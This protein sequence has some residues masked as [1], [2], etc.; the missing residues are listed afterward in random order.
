[1]SFLKNT[2]ATLVGLF[3]FFGLILLI[4]IGII[5]A[6]L[7][8]DE[9]TVKERSILHLKLDKPISEWEHDDPLGEFSFLTNQPNTIGVNKLV[10]TIKAAKE[11]DKIKGIYLEASMLMAG[12]AHIEEIRNALDDFS[13][14][15]KF[16]ITYSELYSEGA[17]Y[18]A[19]VADS[20]F[21][22][23]EGTIDFNG[24]DAE[25]TFYKG[26]LDKLE[27][28]PQ[29]FRV[30]DFKSAV[31]PI[32]R[33]DMSEANRLQL[34]SIL[35]SMYNHVLRNM[36]ESRGMAVERLQEI[37]AQMEVRNPQDA[38]RLKM[39]DRLY[40]LDQVYNSMRSA[41]GL[42]K[43]EKVAL[44]TYDKYKKTVKAYQKADDEIA[45]IVAEGEIVPGEGDNG[46][47]GSEKYAKLIRKARLDDDIKAI[48]LRINSPGGSFIASD[49]MWREVV[50]ARKEKPVIASM[51]NVAASGGYYMAM[52]CDT[53][54]A[55]PNTIT[56][57]IGIF[58]VIF[59]ASEFLENK[60]G[61]TT[62]RVK[63]GE[64]SNLLTMTRSLNDAEKEII[65]KDINEGYETFTSK[66]AQGRN[67]DVAALKQVASGRV[68][69]GI[70]AFE[71]GLVDV[72]GGFDDAIDIA[73]EKASLE[74]GDYKLRY[75]P[76]Q[77]P[78]F[79]RIFDN[80]EEESRAKALKEELGAFY[81]YLKQ[82]EYLK[83]MEGT[84]ARL[85]FDI[86]IK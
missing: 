18:L 26:L 62:D 29:V 67:M 60:L 19:S 30:G 47:I 58:G 83:Y 86:D 82:L 33:K 64:Y 73:A 61:I 66:A 37:S 78:F 49:V 57:S 23:P 13:A 17:Y 85:P 69:S 54:V 38:Q 51:G 31:E 36:A 16:V 74:K 40:Y 6:T 44:I 25:V 50:L 84:Q 76:I 75:Y 11:D 46:Y 45:V 7:S 65:Q 39:V 21:L 35:N 59:N 70:Q 56:G 1:M 10:K 5:S 81:P 52:G 4:G 3:I 77:K 42:K 72:L 24:L 15:D 48:V 55:Q 79:E 71:V 43:E 9:V 8:E 14:S 20:I 68:W 12:F 2:L 28:E 80:V 34:T 27:I 41:L 22:N 63:T 53:I 32:M